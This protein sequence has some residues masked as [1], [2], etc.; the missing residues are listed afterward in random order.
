[1]NKK[2]VFGLLIFSNLIFG[3][4]ISQSSVATA[5][6][7]SKACQK[8]LLQAQKEA[9]HQ[10]GVNIFTS[11]EKKQTI[12]N[13]NEIK[14]VINNSLQ[15]SYG[16][17]TTISKDEKTKYNPNTGYI[18][19]EVNGTFEVDTSKL[20]S[21]LLA[22]SQKYDNQYEN[23][24]SRARALREKNELMQKYFTLKDNITDTHT[25]NYSGSYN[26]GDSL[27]LNECK[28]QLQNKI[29]N[30]TK[31]ELANKYD[32][33]SS[34]IKMDDIE[35]QND[36]QSTTNYGL[37][38]K[39]NGK[40][41]AKAL[42]VKNPYI[43]EIN[44]LNAF[45]GEKQIIDED[46]ESKGPSFGEKFSKN[47]NLFINNL[48]SRRQY[49]ILNEY[50][51]ISDYDLE[52]T[53]INS[54]VSQF[55]YLIHWKKKYYFKLSIGNAKYTK[56]EGDWLYD[57]SFKTVEEYSYKFYSVGVSTFLIQYYGGKS[58][59]D[60]DY[61]VPSSDDIKINNFFNLSWNNDWIIAND[62]ILGTGIVIGGEK[63]WKDNWWTFRLGMMF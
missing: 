56:S 34:L 32:I 57:D 21:Q 59:I 7:K 4:E 3:N 37:V 51:N 20:K 53:R 29:K 52:D 8:A 35:L 23:E 26:C 43:D 54:S 44:S 60:I 46:E 55:E 61:I 15:K 18:T 38:V 17:I 22:L 24:S 6:S 62:I 58:S 2:I 49:I 42:S 33:E 41:E 31:K 11:F 19:C 9:L 27:G 12:M 40:V 45:L 16:Y 50:I 5:D 14:N 30:F 39:Y 63:A 1:M 28:I 36:I 47:Y 13:D 10:S 48:S 25:F